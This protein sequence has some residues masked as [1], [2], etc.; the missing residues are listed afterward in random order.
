MSQLNLAFGSVVGGY[1]PNN[2][3]TELLKISNWTWST[4]AKYP[5]ANSISYYATT[6]YNDMFYVFG[7]IDHSSRSTE[8]S[9]IAK[10]N[11]DT[12]T[13]L[14]VGQLNQPRI[15][16]SV[17]LSQSYFMIIGDNNRNNLTEKCHLADDVMTCEEQQP[18]NIRYG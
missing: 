17:I 11:P 18:E 2:A 9:I 7:G 6:M 1:N 8:L 13:W 15:H 5:Y 12:N 3:E 10:F 4:K 14:K 16:S